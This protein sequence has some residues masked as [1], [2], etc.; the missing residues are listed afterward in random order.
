MFFFSKRHC[1][2]NLHSQVKYK[3]MTGLYLQ[4]S[5]FAMFFS[6]NLNIAHRSA[7]ISVRLLS[8]PTKQFIIR[9]KKLKNKNRWQHIQGPPSATFHLLALK[10]MLCHLQIIVTSSECLFRPE[11]LVSSMPGDSGQ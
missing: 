11:L 6:P 2:N 7:H 4:C 10:H 5:L 9:Q 8:T 1:F 3:Q